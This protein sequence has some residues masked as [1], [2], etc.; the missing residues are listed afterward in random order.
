TPDTV[1]GG[2][3]VVFVNTS[4]N[5]SSYYWSFGD[6]NSSNDSSTYHVYGPPGSY[7]VYL[8]GTNAS[9]CVD[10][11][12]DTVYVIQGLIVPNVFTPNGD[13]QNDVFHVT[14]GGMQTYSIEIFNRWGQKLF[15]SDNPNIDW[16]G[17]SMSGIEEATGPY[18][19]LINATDYNNKTY[20]LHGYLELIR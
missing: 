8:I 17:R 4:T 18:Y 11:A 12:W 13:G 19:Y 5:A 10:T 3:Y 9:G 20:K 2:Q 7:V 1:P 14:V 16:D 15:S 6:G